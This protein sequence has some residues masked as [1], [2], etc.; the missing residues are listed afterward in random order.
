MHQASR[1]ASEP[2]DNESKQ[3]SVSYPTLQKN[4]MVPNLTGFLA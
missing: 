2:F 1:T 3:H 4:P